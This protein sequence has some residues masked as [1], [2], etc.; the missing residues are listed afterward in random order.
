MS[1]LPRILFPLWCCCLFSCRH[2]YPPVS[3]Q[4]A[5]AK[6]QCTARKEDVRGVFRNA[7]RAQKDRKDVCVD[8]LEH[9]KGWVRSDGDDT[10]DPHILLAH[11]QSAAS[12][13]ASADDACE[14]CYPFWC[15]IAESF[16]VRMRDAD[17]PWTFQHKPVAR[18]PGDRL[19]VF[20]GFVTICAVIN[21]GRD[22]G[23][24]STGMDLFISLTFEDEY[25]EYIP[26][27]NEISGV[28][29]MQRGSD[30]E[31]GKMI[32]FPSA[33]TESK[34]SWSVAAK[35][36]QRCA[37]DHFACNVESK[38]GSW[39]P[40]RLLDVA[41]P[42]FSPDTF[43][44]VVTSENELR[45]SEPY[46][47]LSHCWG[48][49]QFLQLK[50]A[51]FDE[52]KTGMNLDKLPKTFRE[53]IQV[54]RRLGVRFLWIDSL[55]IIQD[56]DDLSDW[57]IEAAQMHKVYTHSYCNISAAGAEDSSKG[58]FFSRD[59]R[60]SHT[61]NVRLCVEGLGLAPGVDY[62]D[63]SILDLNFWANGIGKCPLNTRGWVLQERLLSPRVLHFARDQLFW[64]CREYSAAECYPDTLPTTI[65]N[66]VPTN[67]KRLDPASRNMF[68]AADGA[69]D[70]TLFYHRVWDSI[71]KAYSATRLTH[72]SDKLIALSGV[73]KYFAPRI[74][75]TYVAGMWRKFL[76]SSLL[77]NV[78]KEA[79]VDGSSS[80]RAEIYRAPSFSWASVDGEVETRLPS[81]VNL[82]FEVLNVHLDHVSADTTGLVKGG[83]ID[84]RARIRPFNM[85]VKY[86]A[87]MQL[88]FMVVDGVTVK[89]PE[90]KYWELGPLVQLDVGQ[91]SFDEENAEKLLY[92]MPGHKQKTAGEHVRFL[93]LVAVDAERSTFRRI[94]LAETAKAAEIQM[95][96]EAAL[97]RADDVNVTAE[98][99][100]DYWTIRVI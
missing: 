10:D 60:V 18:L 43:R 96:H 33:S 98:A 7:R 80:K 45:Q 1:P 50:K 30:Q 4:T 52:L 14:M 25:R 71:V 51:T 36:V 76:A 28:Y 84:L 75:D 94:G 42:D 26:A 53:A 85:V 83:H 67:F 72:G 93:L 92:Y 9:R 74:D 2:Q 100:E 12:L 77:W 65:R 29:V 19:E 31:A 73:A 21:I 88:L 39:H 61:S 23:L 97:Y 46:T 82:L 47:T 95:L 11:H 70:H 90:K 69:D 99:V 41:N 20:K 13:E 87:G 63:C 58:L 54:T 79:Q 27:L 56:R 68:R 22:A 59:P 78:R 49:A 15:Q 38:A 64:E 44:V 40:T 57:L 17:G 32:P 66:G 6:A 24:E 55:C 3:V 34:E 89:D 5:K 81:N 35:W 48:T 91:A 8:A 62:V 37:S 16:K 86:T